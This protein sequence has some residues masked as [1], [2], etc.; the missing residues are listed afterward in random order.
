LAGIKDVAKLAG[1]G[2]ATVSR[3]LNKSGYVA[4]KT[5]EKIEQAKVELNYTPNEVARDLY[6][7]RTNI[8]AVLVPSIT[9]MFFAEFINAVESCLYDHGYKMMLCNTEKSHNAELEY[10]DMLNRQMVDGIITGVHSLDADKYASL[11]KPIVALDRYLG[12]H[13]PVVTVNHK[14]GGRMAAEA[15]IRSGC[16]NIIHFQGDTIVSAPYHERHTEF[17]HIIKSSG[18]KMHA[19]T[20]ARNRWSDTYFKELIPNILRENP[21]AD[22]VFGVDRVVIEYMNELQKQGKRI[23]EDVKLVSY[24]GT[25]LTKIVTP[26]LT[27]IAQPIAKL[28]DACVSM[29]VKQLDGKR[30]SNCKV[31]LNVSFHQGKTT[32]DCNNKL[33]TLH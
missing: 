9:D 18:I 22:G 28:A 27:C 26:E 24:D 16:H 17:N 5:G 20:L 21:N 13:I 25:V 6:H 1:V 7:K 29:L 33:D 31:T 11:N 12:P 4:A 10:L 15:L 19:Y 8:V 14:E 2:V 32:V 23:P 30:Y 3:Y